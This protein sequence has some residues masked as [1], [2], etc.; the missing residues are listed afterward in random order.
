MFKENPEHYD[1]IFMDVQMPIMDGFEA[2]RQI[3][4]M[5]VPRA[6][7]VPIVAMTANVFREDIEKCLEAGMD[8]HLGKPVDFDEVILMLRK[9][10]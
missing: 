3:R 5:D 4:A 1:L 6:T 2:A 8:N 10:L 7:E 9:Y